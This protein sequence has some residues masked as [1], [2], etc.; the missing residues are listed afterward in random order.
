MDWGKRMRSDTT[1]RQMFFLL[2]MVI[3]TSTT[4]DLPKIAA[5]SSGRSSWI[6]VFATSVFFGLSVMLITNLHN[7]FR[8]KMIFEYSKELGG[9]FFAYIIAIYFV[10]YFLIIG[11]YLKIKLAEI[12]QSNFLP[13]TS[14]LLL[15][16]LSL[17]LS[18][19]VAY[20]GI[21]NVARLT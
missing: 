15:V 5:Q 7:R 8:G 18:G 21:T 20:K 19:Y 1:N 3:T 9:K 2:F 4:I 10:L 12:L 11:T 14:P 6:P 17:L 16:A 13:K